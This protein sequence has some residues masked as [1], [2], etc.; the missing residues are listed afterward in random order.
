MEHKRHLEERME[1]KVKHYVTKGFKVFVFA[2]FIIGLFFLACYVLMRLW[3]WLM[4]D[5]FDLGTISYWQAVGV[6]VL[7]KLLFGFGGGGSSSNKGSKSKKWEKRTKERCNSWK[8]DQEEWKL[9]DR[10]WKEEGETAF[11]K[12]VEDHEAD[13]KTD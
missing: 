11:K 4:P 13:E 1:R 6:L 9:Y 7:A 10:F 5:I 2:I 8:K 12:F 3:N